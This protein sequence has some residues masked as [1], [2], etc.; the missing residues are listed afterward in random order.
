[1]LRFDDRVGHGVIAVHAYA[2]DDYRV[3]G[4]RVFIGFRDVVGP[5]V[6]PPLVVGQYVAFAIEPLAD[7]GACARRLT[8]LDGGLVPRQP[9]AQPAPTSRYPFPVA[10]M[11]TLGVLLLAFVVWA[12]L[13]R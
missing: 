3:P 7:G 8:V 6:Y 9:V 1:M 10:K 13:I 5:P 11:L 12:L 4:D 2:A